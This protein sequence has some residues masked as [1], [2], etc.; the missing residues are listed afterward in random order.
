MGS[1]RL[2]RAEG[3]LA[4]LFAG[5]VDDVRTWDDDLVDVPTPFA[6]LTALDATAVDGEALYRFAK[7][8]IVAGCRHACAWGPGCGRVE[9]AFDAV[10]IDLDES[11]ENIFVLTTAW[12]DEILDEAIWY[13]LYTDRIWVT[14]THPAFVEP[15]CL[16]ALA[17]PSYLD[18]VTR[19]LADVEQLDA[20]LGVGDDTA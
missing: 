14:P 7:R 19:R 3:W 5:V 16:L 6:L 11:L 8:L 9:A 20:D 17:A 2:V 1:V 4:P 15:Q 18:H 12:E 13:S 10:N